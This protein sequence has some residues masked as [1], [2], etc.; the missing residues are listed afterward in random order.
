MTVYG[1]LGTDS[2]FPGSS[3]VV[4]LLIRQSLSDG[5]PQCFLL[6]D[7]EPTAPNEVDVI[8]S[9]AIASTNVGITLERPPNV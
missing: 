5:S 4:D 3:N 9:E 1:A 7:S 8:G 2:T 6:T